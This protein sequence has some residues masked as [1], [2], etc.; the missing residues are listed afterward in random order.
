MLLTPTLL[1]L[2]S[3]TTTAEAA[4]PGKVTW[5][6]NAAAAEAAAQQSGKPVLVFELLGRLDERF[7]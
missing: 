7:A 5:H 4:E 1:I 2:A 6:Q 3:V